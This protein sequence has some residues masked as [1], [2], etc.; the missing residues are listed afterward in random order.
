MDFGFVHLQDVFSRRSIEILYDYIGKINF[1]ERLVEFKYASYDEKS[2]LFKPPGLVQGF[3]EPDPKP[4][5][6]KDHLTGYNHNVN[7][8][9]RCVLQLY[10]QN[11][12]TVDLTERKLANG[13]VLARKYTQET[14]NFLKTFFLRNKQFVENLVVHNKKL[15]PFLCKYPVH[16]YTKLFVNE[17]N[18]GDQEVHCDQPDQTERDT[19]YLIIPLDDCD[20]DMGTTVF[21]DNKHVG[22]YFTNGDSWFNKGHVENFDNEMKKDFELAEYNVPFQVGDAIVFFGDT[23]H[24]GTCNRSK[25]SRKFL[26]IA[27]TKS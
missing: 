5:T 24:R 12:V 6:L 11:H 8:D 23:M 9:K 19:M 26:H 13:T 21:Y 16:K 20:K 17:P 18:C 15:Y 27:W 4:L 7:S 2:G 14:V 22:K 25:K 1:D 3:R 10:N